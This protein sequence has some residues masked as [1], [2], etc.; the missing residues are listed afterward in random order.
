MGPSIGMRVK[1]NTKDQTS[2][3]TM[4]QHQTKPTESSEDE[5]LRTNPLE[6]IIERCD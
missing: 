1:I 6:K 4:S 2:V 3:M 5:I